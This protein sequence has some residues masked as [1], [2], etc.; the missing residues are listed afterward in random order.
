MTNKGRFQAT[1][2]AVTI[3]HTDMDM[4][5]LLKNINEYFHDMIEYA[6]VG[7]EY[8]KDGSPHLHAYIKL[9]KQ[10]RSTTPQCMLQDI[11]GQKGDVQGCK[12]EAS[13]IKY[14]IKHNDYT[15]SN[16]NVEEYVKNVDKKASRSETKGVGNK[17]TTAIEEGKSI[18][19]LTKIFPGY[20]LANMKKVQHFMALKRQWDNEPDPMP[21]GPLREWQEELAKELNGK[22]HD[23][24]I[25]WY[26]DPKG[27]SGKSWMRMWLIDKMKAFLILG[28]RKADICSAYDYQRLIVCD[29]AKSADDFV[30]YD[31]LEQLKDGCVFDSKYESKFKTTGRNHVV[32]FSNA[33]P[34][35]TKLIED[36]WDVR[37]L[38]PVPN[39][40]NK[41]DDEDEGHF[42]RPV[43]VLREKRDK[44]RNGNLGKPIM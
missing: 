7:H 14:I 20:M 5:V 18:K 25:I 26:V 27:N 43:E 40:F 28:G 12:F 42:K 22:P 11:S 13:W 29:I 17:V 31:L 1:K 6:V 4:N 21:D 8:H 41:S 2:L 9:T 24:K 3:P 19:E 38:S 23:R 34:D 44:A 16:I 36:R 30:H 15:A 32:V 37:F 33:E 39:A 10:F 35:Y